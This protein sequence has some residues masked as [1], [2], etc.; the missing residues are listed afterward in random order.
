MLQTE[1]EAALA[2][3]RYAAQRLPENADV[4]DAVAVG[5]NMAASALERECLYSDP[6]LLDYRSS[7]RSSAADSF[8]LRPRSKEAKGALSEMHSALAHTYDALGDVLEARNAYLNAYRLRTELADSDPSNQFAAAQVVKSSLDIFRLRVHADDGTPPSFTEDQA[9]T[10]LASETGRSSA[11][12]LGLERLWLLS[13]LEQ[14]II[15]GDTVRARGLV[16][17]LLGLPQTYDGN[18]GELI[19]GLMSVVIAKT[20]FGED[21]AKQQWLYDVDFRMPWI[22]ALE[23]RDGFG[24][25]RLTSKNPPSQ[26]LSRCSSKL[27]LPLRRILRHF[28]LG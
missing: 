12:Q 14:A 5:M 21:V 24:L 9:T 2:A 16:D 4:H 7:A 22:A 28:D 3:A 13:M 25:P 26:S 6:R 1:M 11:G 23:L 18:D 10:G 8:R 15:S 17:D 20:L 19:V 27:Q